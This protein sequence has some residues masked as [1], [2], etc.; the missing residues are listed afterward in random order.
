MIGG[1][2][3]V[4][5]GEDSRSQFGEVNRVLGVVELL[6]GLTEERAVCGESPED[7][8]VNGAHHSLSCPVS[9]CLTELR[10]ILQ[11]YLW[12]FGKS[13]LHNFIL[14]LCIYLAS[15]NESLKPDLFEA[16]SHSERVDVPAFQVNKRTV[17]AQP[18]VPKERPEQLQRERGDGAVDEEVLVGQGLGQ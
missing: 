9:D 14:S 18:T 16:P 5:A 4:A 7:E 3:T 2:G 11:L 1:I 15:K 6:I 12:G 8:L 17:V 13:F 10:G